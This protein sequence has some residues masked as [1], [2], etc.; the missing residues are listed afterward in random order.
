M[1]N[2]GSFLHFQEFSFILDRLLLNTSPGMEC[3]DVVGISNAVQTIFEVSEW[4]LISENPFY[5][6]SCSSS[7]SSISKCRK[8]LLHCHCFVNSGILV[9]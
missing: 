2:W 3:V 9:K 1:A 6:I 5:V 4:F 7:S 8:K